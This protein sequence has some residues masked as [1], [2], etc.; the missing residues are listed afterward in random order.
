MLGLTFDTLSMIEA[1]SIHVR[2]SVAHVVV[3]VLHNSAKDALMVLSSEFDGFA[4]LVIIG[5]FR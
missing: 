3:I 5:C 2:V 1:V 4:V